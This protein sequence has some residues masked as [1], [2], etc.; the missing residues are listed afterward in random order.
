MISTLTPPEQMPSHLAEPTCAEAYEQAPIRLP[1]G[2]L[3]WVEKV[4]FGL[5]RGLRREAPDDVVELFLEH[6]ERL[7]EVELELKIL[8]ALE[9]FVQRI[10][11]LEAGQREQP[12]V[13]LVV[14]PSYE[15]LAAFS[16]EERQGT[17]FDIAAQLAAHAGPVIRLNPLARHDSVTQCG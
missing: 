10:H 17:E 4:A 5:S 13:L 7:R 1:L 16:E 12:H 2:L 15:V 9:R 8:W 11:S 14:A 3:R 6:P